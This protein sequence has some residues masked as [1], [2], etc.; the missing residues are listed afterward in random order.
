MKKIRFIF[1][2][3]IL[4]NLIYISCNLNPNPF[5][6][7]RRELP[8]GVKVILKEE[9]KVPNIVL[10]LWIR[11]GSAFE[12]ELYGY[13]L[14]HFLEHMLFRNAGNTEI[15]EQI[16]N[17]GGWC[18]GHASHDRVYL[19][20][21]INK[22]Y[23]ND[24]SSIISELIYDLQ[25][26]PMT[27]ENEKD[28]IIKEIEKNLSNPNQ[29]LS[30]LF[31]QYAFNGSNYQYPVIGY[32]ANVE[33]LSITDLTKYMQKNYS[34]DRMILTVVGDFNADSIYADIESKFG[35]AEK[36]D[37]EIELPSLNITQNS[38]YIIRYNP[39]VQ[40]NLIQIGFPIPGIKNN[41]V[42]AFDI[43]ANIVKNPRSN[44]RKFVKRKFNWDID[45]TYSYTGLYHG[46]FYLTLKT[47]EISQLDLNFF[48]LCDSLKYLIS[49]SLEI[50]KSKTKI[51]TKFMKY[52]DTYRG[53]ATAFS[54]Y[55]YY[56]DNL[57]KLDEYLKKIKSVEYDD[58]IR[59]TKKYCKKDNITIVVLSPSLCYPYYQDV[60]DLEFSKVGNNIIRIR[61]PNNLTI[62]YKPYK[63]TPF[64]VLSVIFKNNILLNEESYKKTEN[65]IFGILSDKADKFMDKLDE[66]GG[67]ISPWNSSDGFGLQ[68]ML[69]S[70]KINLGFDIINDL[71]NG[72]ISKEKWND[73]KNNLSKYIFSTYNDLDILK[74]MMYGNRIYGIKPYDHYKDNIKYSFNY[75]NNWYNKLINPSNSIISIWGNALDIELIFKRLGTLKKVEIDTNKTSNKLRPI[76]SGFKEKRINDTNNEQIRILMGF[77]LDKKSYHDYLTCELLNSF[78]FEQLGLNLRGDHGYVYYF[79]IRNMPMWD[80]NLFTIEYQTEINLRN[81]VEEIIWSEINKIA[82]GNLNND[83]IETTKNYLIGQRKSLPDD[84]KKESGYYLDLELSEYNFFNDAQYEEEIRSISK[85]EIIRFVK[86]FLIKEKCAIIIE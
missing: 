82:I 68:I 34:P 57:N 85:D 65:I 59:V 20:L 84:I 26:N 67:T 28:V 74:N 52:L 61:L 6:T 33:K 37:T 47:E 54:T 4:F 8:N 81:K 16:R 24:I 31:W 49:D 27:F 14:T 40:E 83:K 15:W 48:E 76:S 44:I 17:A 60:H 18:N 32:K 13:G 78:L 38:N 75:I 19:E 5:S 10:Q 64:T 70:D 86:N 11:L 63:S 39:K 12:S 41:D 21:E 55:E 3:Y 46:V 62:M 50:S 43:L 45:D 25:I 58:I 69:P 80:V 22:K 77:A 56:L 2:I 35:F 30:N 53:Q 1:I 71:I 7:I 23:W 51:S 72:T 29:L 42:Y 66:F 9:H 79:L 36:K 73:Y